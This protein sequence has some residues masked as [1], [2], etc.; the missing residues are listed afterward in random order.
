MKCH[1][2]GMNWHKI[3]MLFCPCVQGEA[4]AQAGNWPEAE[5]FFLRAKQP[6]AALTMYR[7]AGLWNEALR[8]AEDYLP[9]KVR[10]GTFTKCSALSATLFQHVL[11]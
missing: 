10:G 7:K 8:V 4:A 9:D 6:E 11:T 3:L 1:R 5:G 2:M